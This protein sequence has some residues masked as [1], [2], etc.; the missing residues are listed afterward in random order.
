MKI[1]SF[2]LLLQAGC[3]AASS[4][5]NP[6]I[7]DPA[8]KDIVINEILYRPRANAS[9]YVEYYNASRKVFDAGK[10]FIANRNSSGAISSIKALSNVPFYIY[11]GDYIVATEDPASL[12][13]NYLVKDPRRVVTITTMPSLPNTGG[14]AL[15]L[16]A[17]NEIVDEVNY[18]P[19]WHYKLINSDV[20]V[21]LERIDPAGA[22]QEAANW[23]SAASTAGYGTPGYRNSQYKEINSVD[24]SIA[25]TPAVFSPDNDGRDDIA[26][27]QY[28]VSEPRYIANITIFNTIGKPV[29]YLEKNG[30]L[31]LK[32]YWNWDGLD[33]KGTPLPAGPYIVLAEIF[34]L[35]GKKQQFKNVL[36]LAKAIK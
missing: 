10:L 2:L 13:L 25:M 5:T 27:I 28:A 7:Q 24:A 3:F 17:K 21:A 30:I 18:S 20:G 23:H 4:Q 36:V 35:Q 1:L 11:P 6:V 22:S 8:P 26:T 15:L 9:D 14:Y 19:G 29:R 16:N 12:A 32:G 31:G 33:E 34:N